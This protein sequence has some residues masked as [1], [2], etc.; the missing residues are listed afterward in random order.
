MQKKVELG[1]LIFGVLTIVNLSAEFLRL[2]NLIFL[3]KP[4]LITTIA[5]VY[6]LATKLENRFHL[7]LFLGFVFSIGG[8]T[9]LMFVEEDASKQHFFLL[10]LVSFLITHLFYA[11]AFL[12][13]STKG[14]GFVE[15]NKW[16]IIP[17]ILFLI[18]YSYY[19]WDGIPEDLRIPVV[20][21]STVIVLMAIT[22]L[23]LK[24]QINDSIFQLLILA[25]FLF[26]CSDSIIGLN[27]FKGDI[28]QIP[29]PRLLIM[30]P[31]LLCQYLL[32]R[33]GI[34]LVSLKL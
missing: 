15:K 9:F 7:Y 4:L 1:F 29:Y 8:D 2:P 34:K 17:F 28:L 24:G 22:C 18:A 14:N 27:K 25:V 23:N 11:R 30:I 32:A 31:Y 20:I 6:Y 10:G 26:V 12:A 19:L 16:L 13:L 3:S 5:I 33:A 21:Y